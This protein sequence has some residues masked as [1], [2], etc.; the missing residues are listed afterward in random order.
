[1]TGPRPSHPAAA[2][3]AAAAVL[4]FVALL[5]PAQG[6]L[7]AQ[8]T[9]ATAAAS[10]TSSAAPAPTPLAGPYDPKADASAQLKAA[11]GRA[12]AQGK[13]VLGIVGGNWCSWCRVLERKLKEDPAVAAA[14]ARGFEVVH[15]NYSKENQNRDVLGPFGA[16][17]KTG[18]PYLVVLSPELELLKMQETGS[19]ETADKKHPGYDGAALVAFLE[20]WTPRAPGK[21]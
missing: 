11:G 15:L 17:E 4:V 8:A 7:R 19:L 5:V 9:S 18:Y 1:M 12:K 20:A 21:S 3:R 6:P 13:R 10:G 16:T 14:L 2:V